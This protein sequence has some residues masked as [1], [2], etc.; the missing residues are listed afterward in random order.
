[1]SI[2][3]LVVDDDMKNLL[4]LTLLLEGWGLHVT[5]AGDGEEALD[6]LSEEGECALLLMDI[7]MP[8]MDGYDTIRKVRSDQRFKQLPIIALTVSSGDA[9]RELCLEAGADDFLSKPRNLVELKEV[10]E[11]HLD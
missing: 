11:R 5:A 8:V 3:V 7:I 2:S 6:T 10:I 4:A 1:M 9:E